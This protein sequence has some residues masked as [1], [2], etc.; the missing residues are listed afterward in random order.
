MYY[1]LPPCL[2][3]ENSYALPFVVDR[4]GPSERFTVQITA[5]IL[6]FTMKLVAFFRFVAR[7]VERKQIS[8]GN[9]VRSNDVMNSSDSAFKEKSNH[10]LPK[11]ETHKNEVPPSL[12][13]RLQKM[14]EMVSE[15]SSKPPQI[16]PEKDE[17]L[18]ASLNRINALEA[19][20]EKTKKVLQ[21]TIMKQIEFGEALEHL[22][23]SK[24]RENSKNPPRRHELFVG[25]LGV[26]FNKIIGN[27]HATLVVYNRP[28][29]FN[30]KTILQ[31]WN[32]QGYHS[33]LYKSRL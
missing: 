11:P 29:P 32:A 8:N 7:H 31:G 15:L 19:E 4:K 30:F 2:D 16:P 10:D 17:M 22:K 18:A 3:F 14:E 9:E 13:A 1:A 5:A 27:T 12:L 33:S 24:M 21:A 28:L 20:L 26:L 23:E 25:N 6:A